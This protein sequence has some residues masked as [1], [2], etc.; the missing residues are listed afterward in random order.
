MDSYGLLTSFVTEMMRWVYHVTLLGMVSTWRRGG[1]RGSSRLIKAARLGNIDPAVS[2][3][4]AE[5]QYFVADEAQSLVIVTERT[6]RRRRRD[7]SEGEGPEPAL[8]MLVRASGRPERVNRS[9]GACT[10]SVPE[11]VTGSAKGWCDLRMG[12][13]VWGQF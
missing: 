10:R 12:A 2:T 4:R 3:Q 5:S 1:C 11:C 7:S 8:M 13:G 9:G 6:E